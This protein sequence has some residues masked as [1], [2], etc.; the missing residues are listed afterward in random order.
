MGIY[1]MESLIH[2]LLGSW[3]RLLLTLST[4]H[5]TGLDVPGSRSDCAFGATPNLSSSR[6]Q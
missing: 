3:A 5:F 6:T 4:H 1:L 2:V